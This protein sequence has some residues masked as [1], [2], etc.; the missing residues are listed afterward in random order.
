M[1]GPCRCPSPLP[2]F[3]AWM[4]DGQVIEKWQCPICGRQSVTVR[5][6]PVPPQ[7]LAQAGPGRR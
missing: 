2:I 5:A 7:I 4:P 6:E 1:I 3:K